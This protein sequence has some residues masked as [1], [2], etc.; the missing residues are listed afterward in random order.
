VDWSYDLLTPD[1]KNLFD[2]LSICVGGFDLQA[3]EALGGPTVLDGLG[4]LI[5][6]SLV[7]GQVDEEGAMRYR[8]LEVLRQYGQDRLAAK[9]GIDSAHERH[10]AHYLELA[11]RFDRDSQEGDVS[12]WLPPFQREEGNFRVA[13]DWLRGR[14]S[15]DGLRL[16][17]ALAR[18]W[19]AAGSINDGRA[20]M[21]AMLARSTDDK[22]LL[23]VALYRAGLL[24]YFGDDYPAAIAEMEAS[25]EIKRELGDGA[26]TAR[27]LGT[28]AQVAMASGDGDKAL[29]LAE[30]A[31]ALAVQ[32]HDAR[33]QGW[34]NFHLGAIQF[35]T[36]HPDQAL[37]M[38]ADSLAPL[39]SAG[40][41]TGL[42]YS[43]GTIALIHLD[44]GDHVL[45]RARAIE[46]LDA[47]E[48]HMIWVEDPSWVWLLFLLSDAELRYE[49]AVRIAGAILRLEKEGKVWQRHFRAMFLPRLEGARNRFSSEQAEKML[50]EGAEMTRA[51]LLEEGLGRG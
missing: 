3:A 34:A 36:G 27:R 48:S 16:S 29:R 15:D 10:A 35:M 42:A 11:Q 44:R 24:A 22:Q 9:D 45:G 14:N 18:Y 7:I 33:T 19:Q 40:D 12:A 25:I 4:A 32:Y 50:A 26:A 37:A 28:L 43:L 46:V 1:E 38:L 17:T 39:R 49:S 21:E 5:D 6:K 13:L 31:R 51:E 2:L 30:E 47:T 8:M 41:Y 20:S 23:A